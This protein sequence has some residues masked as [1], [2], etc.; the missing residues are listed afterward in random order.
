MVTLSKLSEF[1]LSF[2]QKVIGRLLTN[3]KFL[4]NV[5]DGLTPEYFENP[6]LEWIINEIIQYYNKYHTYPSM[7]KMHIEI[8]KIENE[9]L[10]ISIVEQLREAYKTI[11]ISNDLDWVEQEFTNF[12]TN[13]QVKKA[14]ITSVDL[15][16]IGDYDGIKQLIN[17][18]LK[19]GQDKNI[20]HVY[21]QDIETR[22]REDSRNP[23]P[24]PWKAFNNITDNGMGKGE[25]ILIFG[26]PKGGKSWAVVNIAAHAMKLGYNVVYYTL[27]LSE[28][29]VG[30]RIDACLTGISVNNLSKHRKEVEEKI[31]KIRGRI[32][33]K[34]YPAGRASLDTIEAHLTQLEHQHGFKAE[35]VIIDYLDLLKNRN[36]TRKDKLDDTED[37]FVDARGMAREF[38]VPVISPSQIGRSGAQDDI[39]QADKI[40]GSY[41]KV[42]I[43][44]F[45]ASLS[46]KRKDKINGTGRWHIMGNRMGLDGV[47]F[48]S[49]MDTS[50]GY[51]DIYENPL[52]DNFFEKDEN[53]FGNDPSSLDEDDKEILKDTF[54]DIFP[55]SK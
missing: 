31:S 26:N 36:R 20:G 39:I 41:K 42:M 11:D 43:A 4:I 2:Q 34:E 48:N 17:N 22:Y 32:R 55:I 46:R 1:G 52:D 33:I 47:T 23:I 8:K 18:A 24:F 13:Q 51:I 27:E 45:A 3:Q 12:C 29:Y 19:T 15:L 5:I 49:K 53:N 14:I 25:L 21:E 7:D 40:A 6:A 50:N 28:S 54:K 10:Q 9:I 44:D 30:K 37:I 38:Q 16:N 35:L